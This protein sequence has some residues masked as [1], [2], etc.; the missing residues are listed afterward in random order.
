M[1]PYGKVK[2]MSERPEP[3][4]DRVREAMRERD[5]RTEEDEADAQPEPDER[6]EPDDDE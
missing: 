4:I 3:D 5:E 1:A 2:G 6:D